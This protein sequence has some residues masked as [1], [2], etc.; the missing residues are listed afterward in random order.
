M[1]DRSVTSN[2]EFVSRIPELLSRARSYSRPEISKFTVSA[3]GYGASGTV[4]LGANLEFPSVGIG[5]CAT[6]H[7]EEFVVCSAVN[8]GER[9]LK[10]LAVSEFPC[11]H[12]RQLLA[13][14]DGTDKLKIYVLQSSSVVG[15]FSIFDLLPHSF[16]PRQLGNTFHPFSIPPWQLVLQNQEDCPSD[17]SSLAELALDFANRSYSVSAESAFVFALT[18]FV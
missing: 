2:E 1:D 10:C 18:A 13:E 15:P 17:F 9:A 11:G 16:G 4:Y 5:L 14:L 12:C 3:A 6:T 8:K 7:A